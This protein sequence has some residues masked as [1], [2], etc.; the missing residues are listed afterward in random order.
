MVVAIRVVSPEEEGIMTTTPE[1]GVAGVV[2]VE[3]TITTISI[4]GHRHPD[5]QETHIIT[6][7]E[8]QILITEVIRISMSFA[9]SLRTVSRGFTPE[10]ALAYFIPYSFKY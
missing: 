8:E 2:V 5:H 4:A 7:A 3:V 10:N 6:T 1:M 9:L